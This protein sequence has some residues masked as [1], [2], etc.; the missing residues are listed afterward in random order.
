MSPITLK[1][2]SFLTT[3]G[4]AISGHPG[5]LRAGRLTSGF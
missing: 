2:Y 3:V 4:E 1:T 5:E